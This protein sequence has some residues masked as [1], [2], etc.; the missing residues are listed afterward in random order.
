MLRDDEW[1]TSLGE[2]GRRR[3]E[4]FDVDRVTAGFLEAL[5]G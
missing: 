2:E 4:D 5:P 3:V 1:R